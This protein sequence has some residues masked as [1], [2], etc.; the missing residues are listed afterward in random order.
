M[1]CNLMTFNCYRESSNRYKSKKKNLGLLFNSF[2]PTLLSSK[3]PTRALGPVEKV[4]LNYTD[5]PLIV[6]LT[7]LTVRVKIF[8]NEYI[9]F[10][11]IVKCLLQ[12]K[13]YQKPSYH[14]ALFF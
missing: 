12:R 11:Q 2:A 10:K 7:S 1:L 6:Q 5:L 13:F 3:I 9:C 4:E 14:W 8:L